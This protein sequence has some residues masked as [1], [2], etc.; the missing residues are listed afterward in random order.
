MVRLVRSKGVGVFFVTQNPLDVPETVLGQLG[1]RVQHAL[2]AF[3]PRDQKAVRTAAETFR[4]NPRI[5][6]AA[7]I[8]EL[9]VGEALVSLLDGKGTPVPVDRAFV[10]P[11]RSRLA[12]LSAEERKRVIRASPV[13]GK[14]D[15]T[16]DRESAYERLLARAAERSA[17]TPPSRPGGQGRA[18]EPRSE[19][20]DTLGAMAK[21]VARS[22]GTQI[23]RELVRGIL[24]S[25]FGSGRRS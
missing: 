19:V 15:E 24:G 23:G 7:A 11:P 6:A 9:G 12:P 5:D 4:Q 21:S 25:L 3:T 17:E 16:V 10:L 22:A 2:R 13:K 20:A 18:A 14:Y 1:N 8:T